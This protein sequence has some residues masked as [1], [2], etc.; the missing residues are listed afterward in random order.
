MIGFGGAA[1]LER[2][3]LSVRVSPL[4]KMGPVPLALQL[5]L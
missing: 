3:S 4:L 5:A 2:T 1:R